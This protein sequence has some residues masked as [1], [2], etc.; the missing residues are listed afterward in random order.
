VLDKLEVRIPRE[1]RF[2]PEFADLYADLASDP[3]GPFRKRGPHY[4]MTGD[5]RAYGHDVILH[6]HCCHGEGNHKIEL[7]DTGKRGFDFLAGEVEQIFDT[8]PLACGLMRVDCAADVPHV[9]VPWFH[10][11]AR[12]KYKQFANEMGEI[13]LE[14]PAASASLPYSQMGKEIQ[15]L[16]FGKRPNCYRIYDKIAEWRVEYRRTFRP[17]PKFSEICGRI[18]RGHAALVEQ[19]TQQGSKYIPEEMTA[20]QVA[21]A[22]ANYLSEHSVNPDAD[23]CPA[24]SFEEVY[25]V[26]ESGYVLTRCERQIGGGEV[27]TIPDP[28]LPAKE[29]QRLETVGE[30]RE[31]GLDYNPYTNFQIMQGGA[32]EPNVENFGL[33]RWMAGM[34]IRDRI[35]REGMQQFR[36]WFNRVASGNAKKLLETTYREFLPLDNGMD[37]EGLLSADELYE[38]YRA[39]F[40]KQLQN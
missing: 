20:E 8:D 7:L 29:W 27:P 30:L 18:K 6:L 37:G 38:R 26:P 33:M 23:D 25:G 11:R 40:Q 12:M 39:S 32:A 36:K 35:E 19:L 5:L 15:T 34:Y 13:K 9:G 2:R 1:A 3:K 16:Y 17:L 28:N 21:E 31:R 24:P 4:T 22:A 14:V 10:Q